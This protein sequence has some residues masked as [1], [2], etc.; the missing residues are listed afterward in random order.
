MAPSAECAE[1]DLTFLTLGETNL[2]SAYLY[3]S[4]R[5]AQQLYWKSPAV[6][7]T[8]IF[9]VRVLCTRIA[10]IYPRVYAVLLRLPFVNIFKRF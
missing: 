4:E 9:V 8:F 7:P 5:T 3:G 2:L 10:R 6:F 1:L